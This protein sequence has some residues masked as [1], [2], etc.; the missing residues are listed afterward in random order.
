[1]KISPELLKKYASNQCSEEEKNLVEQWLHAKNLQEDEQEISNSAFLEEKIW[2]NIQKEIIL[3]PQKKKNIF[4]K[5]ATWTIAAS[6]TL[7][8]GLTLFKQ[9]SSTPEKIMVCQTLAGEMKDITLS[10]GTIVHLNANSTL[11]FPEKFEAENRSVSFSGEAYFEVAKDS[12]HPFLIQTEKSE[13]KVLGTKFNLSAYAD[14]D[15]TLTLDEGKVSF[16]DKKGLS[17]PIIILPNEQVVLSNDGFKKTYVNTKYYKGWLTSDLYFN[18]ESFLSIS[19]KIERRYGVTIQI[20]RASLKDQIYK[21]AFK[22]PTLNN[23]ID[24]LSFVLKFKY[25]IKGNQITIY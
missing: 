5:T 3:E 12:L 16:R 8:I 1:M 21:G 19:H 24:D 6:I 18:N 17:E 9:F 22:D 14:E 7:L 23:L 13:T 10:D 25:E 20:N 2:G 4:L 11:K 15:H